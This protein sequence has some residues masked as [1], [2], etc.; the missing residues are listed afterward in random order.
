MVRKDIVSA[1][2]RGSDAACL[3]P[4][5]RPQIT[6]TIVEHTAIL[7]HA[8]ASD[9]MEGSAIESTVNVHGADSIAVCKGVK[10]FYLLYYRR[11]KQ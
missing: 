7:V 4:F 11:L 5:A 9:G 2:F 6:Q 1:G 8:L 10:I 3:S